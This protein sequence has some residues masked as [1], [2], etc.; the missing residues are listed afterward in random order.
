MEIEIKDGVVF[1]TE[2]SFEEQ[3]YECQNYFYNVMNNNTPNVTYDDFNRPLVETWALDG[4][5]SD[6]AIVRES[7]YKAD[8]YNWVMTNQTIKIVEL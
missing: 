4:A 1:D 7:A 3:S 2:K 5:M 6:Y 8:E